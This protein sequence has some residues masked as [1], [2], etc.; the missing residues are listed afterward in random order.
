MQESPRLRPSEMG[1][2]SWPGHLTRL[3]RGGRATVARPPCPHA[4][5]MGQVVVVSTPRD[6]Q[7][8]GAA[9]TVSTE[10]CWSPAPL[11][12]PS[13]IIGAA[14]IMVIS[15]S[16]TSRTGAPIPLRSLAPHQDCRMLVPWGAAA[17]GQFC[18]G[19]ASPTPPSSKIPE[20]R[21]QRGQGW[22][23]GLPEP[24]FP[25]L[26]NRAGLQT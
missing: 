17:S 2:P 26:Q 20:S 16:S 19:P 25:H 13:N 4:S 8:Q 23:V 14:Q 21:S 18:P 5:S 7:D 1:G 10:P 3:S 22:Q 11:S 24:Q 15:S 9:P 6:C 12:Q